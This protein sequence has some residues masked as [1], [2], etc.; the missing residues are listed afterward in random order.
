MQKPTMKPTT[1]QKSVKPENNWTFVTHTLEYE[2]HHK[3]MIPEISVY[4]KHSLFLVTA[5]VQIK[6]SESPKGF[7][8]FALQP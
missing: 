7:K 2:L 6:V 1:W 8:V 5:N 4:L 3:K